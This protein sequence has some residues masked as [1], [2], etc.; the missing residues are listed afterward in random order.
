MISTS[1]FPRRRKSSRLNNTR[2]AGRQM[3]LV[4]YAELLMNWIPA[5]AGMTGG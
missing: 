1:S 2:E 5:Y 3:G 4:R